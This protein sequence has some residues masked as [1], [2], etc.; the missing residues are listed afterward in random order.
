MN[1][2]DSSAWLEY[3][4]DGPNARYL[5]PPIQE[6]NSRLVPSLT[7]F[8]VFRRVYVQRGEGAALETV[9]AMHR[10]RVVDLDSAQAILAARLAL[11]HKLHMADAIVLAAARA[12]G[13]VLW[14]QDADFE[15]MDLI[16]YRRK[17]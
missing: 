1:I 9:A 17:K 13:A 16:R 7:L 14:T 4:A 11:A 6:T 2:V 8:E 15:G 5:A 12:H 3:F 10:G